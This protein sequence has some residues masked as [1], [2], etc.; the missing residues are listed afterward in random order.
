[1]LHPLA[2][3]AHALAHAVVAGALGR[4]SDLGGATR[5]ARDDSVAV[6]MV[7]PAD[8]LGAARRDGM[9][10]TVMSGAHHAARRALRRCGVAVR[11]MA[12]ADHRRRRGGGIVVMVVRTRIDPAGGEADDDTDRGDGREA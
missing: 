2:V 7:A 6:T 1:L 4:W 12:P 11:M 5:V 9:A 10:V 3:Q 8:R